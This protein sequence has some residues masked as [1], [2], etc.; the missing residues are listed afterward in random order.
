MKAKLQFCVLLDESPKEDVT[1]GI[2]VK[3]KEGTL[4]ETA[5]ATA[6]IKNGQIEYH[7]QDTEREVESIYIKII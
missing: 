3:Y 1:R 2:L 6:D 7:L 4:T 5:Y